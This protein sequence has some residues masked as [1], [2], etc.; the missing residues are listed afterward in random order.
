MAQV[1]LKTAPMALSIPT[2]DCHRSQSVSRAL[3][4]STASKALLLRQKIALL[5][6][7]VR[8]D[9]IYTTPEPLSKSELASAVSALLATNVRLALSLLFLVLKENISP[10][11]DRHLAIL[12]LQATIV[13]NF[14]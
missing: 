9:L 13:T 10:S 2:K 1:W 3:L 11:R 4:E 7:T 6:T 12:V 5:V 14:E 8:L